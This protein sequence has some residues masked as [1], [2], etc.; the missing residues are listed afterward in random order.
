MSQRANPTTIGIFVL[1]AMALLVAG[2]FLFTGHG[3]FQKRPTYVMYF[4]G[5]VYG[6]QVGAPVVFRG[7]Q[8][9][10]VK[11][12]DL[13]YDDTHSQ[14]L[15]P[16]VVE[17][18]SLRLLNSNG[19]DV[20]EDAPDPIS[21]INRG[22]RARL[23]SQSLLT[24]LLYIELDFYPDRPLVYRAPN[25]RL[26]EI[27]TIPSPVQEIAQKLEHLDIEELLG[28]ISAIANTAR[29]FI[30]SPETE[31]TMRSMSRTLANLEALTASLDKRLGPTL[32]GL[33][34][35]VTSVKAN[36]ERVGDAADKFAGVADQAGAPL[37]AVRA[38]AEQMQRAVGTLDTLIA[39]GAPALHNT[40]QTLR[41]LREAARALQEL[42]D[43]LA[44]QP[45]ALLFG[46]QSAR[47]EPQP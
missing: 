13:R 14:L 45:D 3:L 28:D 24:G 32:D 29:Q 34:D 40:E 19:S 23:A 7:V 11:R 8:I 6:L 41:E 33:E 4:E 20:G 15:I 25:K 16:V 17:G 2:I 37:E 27:P 43:T 1:G 9:G 44:R 42:S 35:T 18:T 39:Q 22:L 38:M 26:P 5:S 31:Q 36:M 47:K 46:R 12:I 21:L 10:N 30:N